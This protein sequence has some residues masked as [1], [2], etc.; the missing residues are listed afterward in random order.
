MFGKYIGTRL[1][2]FE[3]VSGKSD[4]DADLCIQLS[5]NVATN[6]VTCARLLFAFIGNSDRNRDDEILNILKTDTND[7]ED[8]TKL[9]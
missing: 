7:E 1:G 5:L 8:P 2:T 3:L 4:A 9:W 6:F